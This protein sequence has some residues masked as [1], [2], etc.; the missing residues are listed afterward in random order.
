MNLKSIFGAIFINFLSLVIYE[1]LSGETSDLLSDGYFG[2]LLEI[3]ILE[4]VARIGLE[5]FT[6]FGWALS[7]IARITGKISFLGGT[8]LLYK[9][10]P[11]KFFF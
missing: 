5:M 9:I 6:G 3:E 8:K 4:K 11:T 10:R 1:Y 7:Y 2:I